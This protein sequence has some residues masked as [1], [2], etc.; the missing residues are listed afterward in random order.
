MRSVA[1]VAVAASLS[2]VRASGGQG[3]GL[4]TVMVGD[5]GG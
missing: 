4:P 5:E 3:E 2:T 1:A